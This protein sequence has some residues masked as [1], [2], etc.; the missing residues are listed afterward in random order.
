MRTVIT[1]RSFAAPV[2]QLLRRREALKTVL[3]KQIHVANGLSKLEGLH[4][5]EAQWAWDV[6]EEVTQKLNRVEDQLTH[7]VD[8]EWDPSRISAYDIELSLREYEL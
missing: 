7:D 5:R 6:V 3:N 8:W 1:C 4:S 2:R